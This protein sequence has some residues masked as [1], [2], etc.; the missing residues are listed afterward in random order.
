MQISTDS[1]FAT[2][3]SGSPFAITTP[4]TAQNFT[5]VQGTTYYIRE[6]MIGTGG[7]TNGPA[8]MF[9]FDTRLLAPTGLTATLI[10]V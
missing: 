5:F 8:L 10:Y 4:G 9:L 1:G 3:I 7:T 6:Q 2:Q